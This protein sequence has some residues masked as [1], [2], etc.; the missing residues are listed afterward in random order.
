MHD[1]A[2]LDRDRL[3]REGERHLGV[4]LDQ[5]DGDTLQARQRRRKLLDDDRREPL[6]RLVEKQ[7]RRIGH[8]RAAH[9]EHL[10][11]ATGEL[12]SP[13][14]A[15]LLQAWKKAVD[16][17]KAPMAAPCRDGE[18]LLARERK[19]DDYLLR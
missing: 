5:D 13:V 4:L 7:Q 3:L 10:L 17:P 8:E 9:G 19:K 18:V 14:R 2:A 15:A 11:L 12:V 1:A 6:E 16:L